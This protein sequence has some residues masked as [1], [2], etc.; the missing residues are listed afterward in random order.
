[1]N[2]PP[3][4]PPQL[5]QAPVAPRKGLHP[6]AWVGIGCGGLLIVAIIA[7][8]FIFGAAKRLYDETVSEFVKNPEKTVAEQVVKMNPDL[9]MLYEDDEAGEM[10]IRNTAT[11]EETTISYQDLAK[12]KLTIKGE[13]GSL[14]QL[15][16][17]DIS[18]VPAWV[19]AYPTMSDP[20][21]PYHQD[22]AGEI[23][24]LLSFSTT[25]TPAEVVAFYESGMR[26]ASQTS[27]SFANIGD[28]NTSSKTFKDGKKTLTISAQKSPTEPTQVQVSYQEM[29]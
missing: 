24:G 15:G 25:D 28:L 16:S 13:D 9:E 3:P 19:P 5:N 7:G 10:T 17:A 1:M 22:K 21:I 20:V 6:L 12:G 11:G 23:Q 29:P 2:T 8:A 18:V 26:G 27:S 14:T 4:Q